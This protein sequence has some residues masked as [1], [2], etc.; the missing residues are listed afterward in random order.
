MG[1]PNTGARIMRASVAEG[2]Q[3]LDDIWRTNCK[4]IKKGTA[5]IQ[6]GQNG[7]F[8]PFNGIFINQDAAQVGSPLEI[9][10]SEVESYS[11]QVRL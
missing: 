4:Y 11:W 10:Q 8:V 5:P 7:I 1:Y 9:P 6:P 3:R 2:E